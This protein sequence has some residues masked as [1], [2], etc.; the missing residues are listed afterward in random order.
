MT[1]AA[2]VAGWSSRSAGAQGAGVTALLDRAMQEALRT[3]PQ[4][5]TITGL[6]TGRNAAARGGL[7]DRS[8]AGLAIQRRVFQD[9]KA[10]LDRYDPASL[11]PAEARLTSACTSLV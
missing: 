3:S 11:T 1:A 2:A 10:G 7:D 8:P 4:L 9:L 6:D 5:M